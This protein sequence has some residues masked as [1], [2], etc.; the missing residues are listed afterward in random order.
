MKRT[1]CILLA[2]T[3]FLTA[4]VTA[5]AAN[6][7]DD[8]KAVLAADFQKMFDSS[9]HKDVIVTADDF[10]ITE[11]Y[12]FNNG[13]TYFRFSE[14]L[15]L[16]YATPE[17]EA[18]FGPYAY[19]Y[20]PGDSRKIYNEHQIYTIPEAYRAGIIN[21]SIVEQLAAM[22]KVHLEDRDAL[23]RE[24]MTLYA[25]D[26]YEDDYSSE[27]DVDFTFYQELTQTGSVGD[28]A[29]V[30]NLIAYKLNIDREDGAYNYTVG[31][32]RINAKDSADIY[33][34][35]LYDCDKGDVGS[36]SLA[37]AYENGWIDD[38]VL[39]ELAEGN[40]EFLPFVRGDADNDGTI[41]IFDTTAIQRHIADMEL[42]FNQEDVEQQLAEAIYH[43][44][45]ADADMDSYVSIFDAT[46]IQRT[47]A[48][49][50][51]IDGNEK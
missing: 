36:C 23:L 11:R 26:M 9:L 17:Y 41:S 27:Q 1:V 12:D 45:L 33:Y 25:Y 18:F 51:D 43:R 29:V 47:L 6:T 4:A 30:C 34:I 15:G 22:G 24:N 16:G 13:A 35:Y 40:D 50:C 42:L 32:Y 39:D 31:P 37:E 8:I 7:D 14:Q 28:G 46:R 2:L 38:K 21:D 48:D 5:Y 3:M 20:S 19:I 10:S 49:L 44:D